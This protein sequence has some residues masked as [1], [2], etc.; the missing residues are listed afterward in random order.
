MTDLP[1]FIIH[2]QRA[3]GRR[4]QVDALLSHLGPLAE[5]MPAVDG[6][7]LTEA[8]LA[9]HLSPR[10]RPSYPFRLRRSEVAIFLSHRACW[11]R[12]VEGKLDA[13][14]ILEDD[15]D[16]GPDFPAAL[17]LARHQA[18]AGAY[19]RLPLLN[20]E[21]PQA[22][23][24]VHGGTR[25][26]RPRVIGLGC[27]GQVVTR[28]AAEHLLQVTETFDR[29]VDVLLQARWAHGAPVLSVWPSGISERSGDLGGSLNTAPKPLVQKLMQELRR[30]LYRALVSVLSR[31]K[32]AA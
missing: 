16:L 25:L 9:T 15:V 28:G 21:T 13:A 31:R 12:I 8:Q 17:A 14:L 10:F 23:L 19:V 27:L 22:V 4:A 6:T 24:A 7:L 26:Y 1:A 5:V 32:G 2:L 3:T 30:P 11:R 18:A 20:R 29:P